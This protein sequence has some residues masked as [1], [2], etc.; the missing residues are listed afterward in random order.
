MKCNTGLKWVKTTILV[1]YSSQ[2][3]VDREKYRVFLTNIKHN[4]QTKSKPFSQQTFASL[5]FSRSSKFKP[6][7]MNL[8]RKKQ[9]L[10]TI[11]GKCLKKD[12]IRGVPKSIL[13]IVSQ[14]CIEPTLNFLIIGEHDRKIIKLLYFFTNLSFI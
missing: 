10:T 8:N 12:L 5:V 6:S 1:L 4:K 3:G 2:S 13:R 14:L 7:F 9:A 11:T